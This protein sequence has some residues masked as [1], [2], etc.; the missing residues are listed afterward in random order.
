[1]TPAL[2]ITRGTAT[3]EE[4]AALTASIAALIARGSATPLPGAAT[5]PAAVPTFGATHPGQPTALANHAPAASAWT[6][7]RAAWK[8]P[9]RL[10]SWPPA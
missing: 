9:G 2:T 8:S 1:M 3:P 7:R 10:G 5:A 4:V 6:R